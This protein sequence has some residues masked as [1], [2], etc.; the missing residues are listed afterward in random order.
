[1]GDIVVDST[2]SKLLSVD[3]D[4]V[5]QEAALNEQL[6]AI[7]VKRASLQTV[8]NMFEAKNQTTA[9]NLKSAPEPTAIAAVGSGVPTTAPTKVSSSRQPSKAK[10][11]AAKPRKSSSSPK[12]NRRGWREYVRDEYRKMP[13]PAVV[14]SILKGQPQKVFAIAEVVDTIFMQTIPQTARTSARERVS[15]ILAE[16]ARKEQWYRGRESGCYRFSK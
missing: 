5:A 13:L 1:M 14:T 6:E 15:N 10:A 11:K 2:L 3:S 16:G 7:K 4:L 12:S 8:L 9:P